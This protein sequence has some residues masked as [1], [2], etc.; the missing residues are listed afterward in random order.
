MSPFRLSIAPRAIA[1]AL[2]I[3]VTATVTAA[4]AGI[5]SGDFS[6]EVSPSP[7]VATVRPG[8]PA[9]LEL[10]IR[11]ASTKPEEL[12]IEARLF[13]VKHPG[14]EI[15][16]STSTPRDLAAWVTFSRPTFTVAPGAWT[17]QA[18]TVSLPEAAGFSYP[19][20][21][22]ISRIN[23]PASA[24]GG[25]LLKGAIAVFTL[26]NIDKP[27]ATRMLALDDFS[28]S[29]SVYEFLPAVLT[30]KL[31]NTG[32]SIVQPYGNIYIQ[33][34]NNDP[35]PLA[36]MPLNDA[37]GYILP[38][39][40]KEISVQWSEGFPRYVTSQPD[41]GGTP[42]TTLTW[43]WQRL[44]DFRFGR[45]TAKVVAV[46]ND[47]TRDVPVTGEISFWVIPWRILLG[48]LVIVLVFG[49]GAWS[50][51]RRLSRGFALFPSRRRGR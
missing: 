39:S 34:R 28:P 24:V 8:V 37:R 25:N 36:V 33:R 50:L 22:V 23:E 44:A 42:T 5:P 10:R 32:N 11:N 9:S 48:L 12:K 29:Q 46:Y 16:L 51:V 49:F 30:L 14:G 27:G 21:I 6:L 31:K 7:L 4:A 45:Y 13:T 1:A 15:T 47:G 17:S 2:F 19:F 26:I 18:V 20:A 38:G 40:T 3:S 43:N 41:A 35:E